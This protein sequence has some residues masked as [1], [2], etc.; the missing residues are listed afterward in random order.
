MEK[1]RLIWAH[2]QSELEYKLGSSTHTTEQERSHLHLWFQR[3]WPCDSQVPVC[4][5]RFCLPIPFLLLITEDCRLHAPNSL[6]AGLLQGSAKRRLWFWREK[7]EYLPLLAS[8]GI[9]SKA[10]ISSLAPNALRWPRTSPRGWGLLLVT[11]DV[12]SSNTVLFLC[13]SRLGSSLMLQWS[14]PAVANLRSVS[15]KVGTQSVTLKETLLGSGKYRVSTWEWVS[16]KHPVG[17]ALMQTLGHLRVSSL[18]V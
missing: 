1:T 6:S 9:S 5:E 7:P 14:F 12:R 2:I 16:P 11:L 4:S 3:T 18:S 8:G 15:L 10:C 13:P 17:R